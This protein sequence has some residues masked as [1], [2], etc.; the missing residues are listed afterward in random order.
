MEV[1]AVGRFIATVGIPG[2]LAIYL[3]R[4]VTGNLNGKLDRLTQSMDRLA[5]RIEQLVER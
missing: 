3:V 4:W 5:D 1:D 2:A